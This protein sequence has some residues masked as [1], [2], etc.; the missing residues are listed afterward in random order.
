MKALIG[1]DRTIED[2]EVVSGHPML[3]PAAMEAVKQW[4]YKP[5]IWEGQAVEV[6]TTIRVNFQLE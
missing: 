3:I 2:L 4:Q 5:S 1:R 6:E